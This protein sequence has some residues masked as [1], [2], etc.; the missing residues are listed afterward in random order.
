MVT[1]SHGY[2]EEARW[3]LVIIIAGLR[4]A[5]VK[6]MMIQLV[7]MAIDNSH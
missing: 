4:A 3:L 6:M 2:T 7:G 1:I 5:I